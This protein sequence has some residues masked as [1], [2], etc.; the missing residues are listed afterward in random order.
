MLLGNENICLHR[1]MY[2]S[3]HSSMVHN[4]K[5]EQSKCP[6]SDAWLEEIWYLYTGILFSCEKNEVLIWATAW[7]TLENTTLSERSQAHKTTNPR[8]PSIGD[9]QK[10]TE[11]HSGW[12]AA[13]VQVGRNGKWPLVGTGFLSGWWECSKVD[14][15]DGRIILWR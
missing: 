1:N 14:G 10:S 2:P 9:I 11:T 3:D 8:I 4:Q 6:S 7:M 12:E 13:R 15:G 5:W